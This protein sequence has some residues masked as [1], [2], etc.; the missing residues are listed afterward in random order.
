MTHDEIIQWLMAGDPAI[1]FQTARDLLGEERPDLQARIATEGWGKAFL[2]ARNADGGWGRKYYYPKWAC[3][4]YVLM[5]LVNIAFPPTHSEIA[6][7]VHKIAAQRVSQ[8]GGFAI[9]IGDRKSDTCV[10]GMALNFGAYFGTPEASLRTFVDFLISVQLPDGGFNCMINRSGCTHSSLHSTLSV[11]EGL[12]R[13]DAEGYSYRRDDL[14]RI[15]DEAR[16]FILRKRFFRSERT[17]KVIN[18]DFLKLRTPPRWY[19]NV[20]RALDHFQ[21]ARRPF[22]PAMTDA[23]EH[24]QARCRP[25]GRW[26]RG[27]K[28][29]GQTLFDMENPRGPGRWNSLMALRVLKAYPRT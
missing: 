23:L 5:D 15:A 3:T 22:D 26:P 24:I 4:H 20:L 9:A 29:P 14:H 13:Y 19:Y 25:D 18:S 8:D 12:H 16:A 2:D 7:L 10:T 11:L 28:V 6:P 21:V 17:G 27:P 1:A